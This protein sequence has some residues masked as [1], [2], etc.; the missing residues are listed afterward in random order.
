MEWTWYTVLEHVLPRAMELD[1][2][3]NYVASPMLVEAPTLE[4]G[5]LTQNPFTVRFRIRDAAVWEDGTPI[6]SADFA[7]TWR[8]NV[9]TRYAYGKEAYHLIEGVDTTDPKVAVIRF[10]EP[11]A[12][13]PELF[14]GTSGFV[15]K[16]AAFPNKARQEKPDLSDRMMDTIPFSGGPWILQSW[17]PDQAIL[18]R[19]DEYFG[20]KP[21]LDQITMVPR[22]DQSTEIQ[23]VVVGEIQA[24]YPAASDTPLLDTTGN[25][26]VVGDDGLAVE[27][28]MFNLT[29]PPLDDPL[30]RQ[31]VL[32]ALDRQAVVDQLASINNPQ[33][34]VLNCGF[35][36]VPQ[37]GSW[38]RTHPFERYTYEPARARQLLEQAGYDCS[39]SPCTKDGK[40]LRI[41]FST[42]ATSTLR[43]SAEDI[44]VSGALDAGIEF[45]VKNVE[46]S[47]LGDSRCPFGFREVQVSLCPVTAASDPTVTDRF[48]C[49]EIASRDNEYSGH[50][51]SGWCNPKAD[52]LMRA[53][54][55]ALDPSNRLDLMDQ[56]YELE[57][58]D[59]IGIPLFVRPAVSIWRPDQIAGPIGLWNGTPYGLFFNMGDWYLV[60]R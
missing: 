14:G 1:V 59:A 58:E 60:Q 52:L 53:S 31:A 26:A 10:E 49:D 55:R 23:S 40:K 44:L 18:V 36:A 9:S 29:K 46:T 25:P 17:S 16:A 51:W 32:S 11:Y 37:L 41:Q 24:I 7:F 19:N 6:T 56:V 15:L 8:A 38:C 39:T 48:A 54:D 2:E 33:A 43:T 35:V 20:R 21:I 28:V 50:N 45:R 5:G 4:N 3:G 34:Q 47:L 27:S 22:T 30:V 57:A 42:R 12:P 13:W